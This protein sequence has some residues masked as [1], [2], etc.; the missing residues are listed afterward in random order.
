M[1]RV[2][3]TW[4]ILFR[5]NL[6]D[7]KSNFGELS[8]ILI[9]SFM[10]LLVFSG[11]LSASN[12]MKVEFY[13][14][15]NKSNLADEW[16]LVNNGKLRIDKLN[17]D[18]NIKYFQKQFVFNA[19]TGSENSKKMLQVAATSSNDI[20]KPSVVKGSGFNASQKGIWIDKNYAYENNLKVGDPI[21]IK[22]DL[23]ERKLKINGIII[24]P[25]YI[26]YTDTSNNIVANH[27][28]SGYAI[29]NYKS[30]SLSESKVNQILV[31]GKAGVTSKKLKSSLNKDLGTTVVSISNR[32]E[33]NNV[34]KFKDKANSVEKLSILFCL[35][36]FSL[37]ILT[38]A[39]TMSRLIHAQR[40]NIGLLR[41]LGFSKALN[42]FH[43]MQYG[44]VTTLIGGVLGLILGPILIGPLILKKQEPLFI[45]ISWQVHSTNL[46]W[47]MLILLLLVS[48]CTSLMAVRKSVRN[49][50]AKIL[51]DDMAPSKSQHV[52]FFTKNLGLDFKW[53]LRD[54]SRNKI[55]EL[56]GIIAIIGSL[57]LIIASLGI[58]N[59][60]VRTNKDTFG[61][62][63][64]YKNELKLKRSSLM[65]LDKLTAKLDDD[66]QMVEQVPM[67]IQSAA[68][69]EL[70][71]GTIV[72]DGIYLSLPSANGIV[73]SLNN[74]SGVYISALVAKKLNI[75]TNQNIRLKTTLSTK[76]VVVPVLGI[77]NVSSP[78]GVYLSSTYWQSL[79]QKFS[80][81]SIY[82][83]QAID[84]STRNLGIVNQTNSL[85]HNLGNADTVLSSFQSVIALLIIFSLLLSWFVLY[86]LGMLNFT[87]RYREYATMKILGF[88]LNEIRSTII[89]DSLMTWLVGTIIGLPVGLL[90]LSAYVNIANSQTT[91]F[92]AQI[93]MFR[94]FLAVAIVFV[95]TFI[96]SLVVARQVKK[97]NMASALKSVD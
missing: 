74:K 32:N 70:S 57:M 56:I 54:K 94:L 71:T 92:F 40:Q 14:W 6:R 73:R 68:K 27:K 43:F 77:V 11:L 5:K 47:L 8:S 7:F 44:L 90:F 20:S 59:S 41:A 46:S 28:K 52:S 38:T 93:G 13:K 51:Q 63:F 35:V 91:Q 95:N 58:Q 75:Q 29:T 62:T 37:V 67:N 10:S 72:G 16:V 87:E 96:I 18:T 97:I 80:P 24:S 15:A 55:K 25:N 21:N 34:A 83:G 82:T 36:L 22:T 64:M 89:K 60:L 1:I 31:S 19:Y 45:M 85:L 50:P 42:Y 26:G 33:N 76:A 49:T 65:A 17:S 39:T 81:T 23:G 86:N 48:V 79:N 69:E 30:M 66:V 84:K 9:L 53:V 12:G 3:N 61:S 4:M 78:Q 2:I 88:R